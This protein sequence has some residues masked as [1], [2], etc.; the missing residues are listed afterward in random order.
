MRGYA[1]LRALKKEAFRR[2]DKMYMVD[3]AGAWIAFSNIVAT[4]I[5][6][7]GYTSSYNFC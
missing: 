3:D 2:D 7:D 6:G 1:V 5:I 4:L